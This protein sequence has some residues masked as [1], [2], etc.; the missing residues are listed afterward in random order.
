MSILQEIWAGSETNEERIDTYRYVFEL[1]NRLE[2]TCKLARDNLAHA[3]MRY[4]KYFDRN[5][6]VRSLE[7]GSKVLLMLPTDHN[8]LMMRWKGPYTILS[9]VGINDYKIQIGDNVKVFHANMIKL[10]L[11]RPETS[12]MSVVEGSDG[13]VPRTL[14]ESTTLEPG[15][16]LRSVEPAD[17]VKDDG[18][19]VVATAAI[20]D[21]DDDPS[22]EV[23]PL[24]G[25]RSESVADV[26]V[27]ESLTSSQAGEV[28]ALMHS[29]GEIFTEKPGC[30]HLAEHT[31]SLNT[32]KPIRVKPYPI[33]FSKVSTIEREVDKMLR[34]GVIEPSKS[35]YIS[36]LLLVKKA[37]GTNRPVVDFRRLNKET[38]FDAEPMPNPELIFARLTNDLFFSKLDC[39]RGYWQI[40]MYSADKEKTAFSSGFFRLAW[41]TP[42]PAI[43]V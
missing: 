24:L 32:L 39:S 34:L 13:R 1:R 36:P 40:A 18:K 3:Q 8:K 16:R 7:V 38:V 29:V 15:S 43:A 17:V 4:K 5:A 27:H 9:K 6:M 37:D 10:Y 30:T 33:P 35:P 11:K 19:I 14:T 12:A 28:L 26:K 21:P 42:A 41:L 23:E 2:S 20:L 31:I 22:L 25:D